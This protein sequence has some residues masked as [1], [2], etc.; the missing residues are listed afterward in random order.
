MSI[1]RF[2]TL[3][4]ADQKTP[5]SGMLRL[6]QSFDFVEWGVLYDRGCAGTSR[7]PTL[8]WIE[9]FARKAQKKGMNIALHVCGAAVTALLDAVE[10]FS[11]LDYPEDVKRL[12]SLMENFDRVQLNTC[13]KESRIQAYRK[14]VQVIHRTEAR[15]RVILQWNS[16]NASVCEQLSGEYG[17][18]SVVDSS[19]GRGLTP[20]AWPELT[21]WLVGRRGYAGGLGPDNIQAQLEILDR[22]A[23][24]RTYWVDMESKLRNNED[25]LDLNLCE[26]V[27]DQA[28]AFVQTRRRI[29]SAVYGTGTRKVA[30]LK[31]LWLN[32]WVARST[33]PAQLIIPPVSASKAVTFSRASGEF[34]SFEPSESPSEAHS[35]F[36]R[37]RIALMPNADDESWNAWPVSEPHLVARGKDLTEAGLRAIVL[38]HFGPTVPKN[39][40]WL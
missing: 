19:G 8:D 17:F 35:L 10:N 37:E 36:F 27:L 2:V 11:H 25:Q 16:H 6:S 38:K 18:E 7:Y 24:G 13:A 40:Y 20:T 34:F 32:W 1:L 5:F 12:L 39:V 14:L 3:T 30:N 9:T 26:S 33:R 15:T 31:G 22:L 21:E 28:Y 4:G 23:G 29:E